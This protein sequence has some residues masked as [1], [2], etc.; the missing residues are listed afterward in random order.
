MYVSVVGLV[1]S[2]LFCLIWGVIRK[3]CCLFY[4]FDGSNLALLLKAW[5]MVMKIS[6]V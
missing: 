1:W 4:V 6:D 5:Q 2:W 3:I